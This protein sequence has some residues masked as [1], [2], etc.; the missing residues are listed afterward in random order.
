MEIDQEQKLAYE[1]EI[2][3]CKRAL[4]EVLIQND[5]VSKG[6]FEFLLKFVKISLI[7]IKVHT[8]NNLLILI[9]IHWQNF[10]FAAKDQNLNFEMNINPNC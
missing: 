10:N 5:N 7:L 9:K 4:R 2:M 3:I 6:K 1:N 8:I